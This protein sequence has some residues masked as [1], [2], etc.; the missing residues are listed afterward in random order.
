MFPLIFQSLCAVHIR[1][2]LCNILPGPGLIC[3]CN[4]VYEICAK[5]LLEEIFMCASSFLACAHLT[6]C[7]RMHSLE[8]TLA[9]IELIALSARELCVLYLYPRKLRSFRYMESARIQRH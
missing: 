5:T 1:F 2:L 7:A 8:G 4:D 3:I 6:V 9:L